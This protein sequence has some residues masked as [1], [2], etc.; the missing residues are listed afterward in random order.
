M[1]SFMNDIKVKTAG[2]WEIV[3]I[4]ITTIPGKEYTFSFDCTVIT[5][6]KPLENYYGIVYQ[7][8]TKVEGSNNLNN[9]LATG[10]LLSGA[11]SQ[12]YSLN[13]VAT[14]NMTYLAFNFGF[15]AD[16]QNIE[17]KIGNFSLYYEV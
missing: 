7:A 15:A 2:G 5:P 3:Y 9:S 17:V 13:F 11:S 1:T 12:S 4:P 14:T 8:L 6:Y 10:S 16:N